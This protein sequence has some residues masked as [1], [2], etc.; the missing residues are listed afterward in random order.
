VAAPAVW[1]GMGVR[2]VLAFLWRQIRVR[3]PNAL[4][5]SAAVSLL[6]AAVAALITA[7]VLGGARVLL[8]LAVLGLGLDITPEPLMAALFGLGL[9]MPAGAPALSPATAA[10]VSGAGMVFAL[11]LVLPGV[12]Y[13]RGLCELFLALRGADEPPAP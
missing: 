11:G 5:F 12:V 6:T 8:A 2:A 1:S 10:A 9:R 7:I 13:L 4:L 3:L